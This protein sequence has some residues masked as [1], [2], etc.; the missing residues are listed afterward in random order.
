[1]KRK[2]K[3][4]LIIST[5]DEIMASYSSNEIWLEDLINEVF[6]KTKNF[7]Y[8]ITSFTSEEEWKKRISFYCSSRLKAN[9]W[10]KIKK[11]N[12]KLYKRFF[13]WD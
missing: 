4:K 7:P 11:R 1:M 6:L 2:E 10:I 13:N 12:K 8:I 5:I 3:N 9:G